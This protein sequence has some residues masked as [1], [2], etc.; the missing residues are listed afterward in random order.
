MWGD[1]AHQGS[2]AGSKAVC[3]RAGVPRRKQLP[4]AVSVSHPGLTAARNM[5]P[6][7]TSVLGKE[8][9]TAHIHSERLLFLLFL[10]LARSA[11]LTKK[12]E[13]H[14]SLLIHSFR[15]KQKSSFGIS[16]PSANLTGLLNDHMLDFS[17]LSVC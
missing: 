14:L 6:L 4:L 11:R 5:R 13:S 1:L 7:E 3:E 10:A 15:H 9:R 2:Q 8:D 16:T 12:K 17:S